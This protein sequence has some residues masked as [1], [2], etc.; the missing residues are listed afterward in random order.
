MSMGYAVIIRRRCRVAG[1]T[2]EVG[3][4]VEVP[5]ATAAGLLGC[6]HELADAS[7]A[8]ALRDELQ[9]EFQAQAV[10][11]PV[12]GQSPAAAQQ[13][14]ADAEQAMKPRQRIGFLP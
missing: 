8:D 10:A 14:V 13:T 11:A 7:D 2:V 5:A 12:F 4:T 3:A 1:Q 6:G 9:A